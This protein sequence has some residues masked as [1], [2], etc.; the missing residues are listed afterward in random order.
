MLALEM[1]LIIA[2]FALAGNQEKSG[3][4][5][6]ITLIY[7]VMLG[8][9]LAGFYATFFLQPAMN[10]KMQVPHCKGSIFGEEAYH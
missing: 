5:L 7:Y 6:V 9:V 4:P 8:L 2:T 1:F 3:G 10:K